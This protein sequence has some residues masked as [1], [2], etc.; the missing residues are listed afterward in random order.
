[1]TN[2]NPQGFLAKVAARMKLI[3][4]ETTDLR[5]GIFERNKAET[6]TARLFEERNGFQLLYKFGGYKKLGYEAGNIRQRRIDCGIFREGKKIVAA[7]F[8]EF[9]MLEYP[10]D[11]DFFWEMDEPSSEIANTAIAYLSG[12]DSYKIYENGNLILLN[13]LASSAPAARREWAPLLTDFIEKRL[14]GNAFVIITNP[15]PH[16]VVRVINGGYDDDAMQEFAARRHDA[17]LTFA[18][19]L[20]GFE[21]YSADARTRRWMFKLA[22][23]HKDDRPDFRNFEITDLNDAYRVENRRVR[24]RSR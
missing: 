18:E 12:W 7:D 24:G 4:H 19:Q 16:D 10:T 9:K 6:E 8:L 21:R 2:I 20:L 13:H 11:H 5:E 1:M 15:Y 22:D 14:L 3:R 23:R 17:K